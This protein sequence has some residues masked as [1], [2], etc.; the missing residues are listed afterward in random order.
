MRR[1]D[2]A[3]SEVAARPP[4]QIKHL[5]TATGVQ[6]GCRL[7]QQNQAGIVNDCLRQLDPLFHAGRVLAHAPVAGLIKANVPHG[8]G[9][10]RPGL[11]RRQAAHL[12]H[13]RQEF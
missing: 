6:S 7:I 2:D 9:C 13:V 12:R 1:K 11:R 10:P 3:D 8:V 4:D 5:L